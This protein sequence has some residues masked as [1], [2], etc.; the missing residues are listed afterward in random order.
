M[1]RKKKYERQKPTYVTHEVRVPDEN[2]VERF[3]HLVAGHSEGAY[4]VP[5]EYDP[6]AQ[7]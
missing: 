2:E 1:F 3:L 5:V 4:D 7:R 6:W